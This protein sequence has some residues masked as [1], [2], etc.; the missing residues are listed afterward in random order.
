PSRFR[1]P[2]PLQAETEAI[3]EAARLLASAQ[4]PVIVADYVGRNHEA[5]SSLVELADLLSIPVVDLGARLNFPN[6]HALNLTGKNQD[7]IANADVF[8]GLDV[9]DLYGVLVK[10]DPE[11]HTVRP[12]TKAGCKVIHV[13]VADLAV[14]SLTSDF[15]ELAPV[16]LPITA[17]TRVFLPALV[18]EVRRDGKFSKS[19]VEERRKVLAAQHD[20]MHS[21]WENI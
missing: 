4:N 13:T 19:V 16:D 9:T 7:L 6:T 10:Q 1:P 5:V 2:A 21:H 8:M 20:E 15:Q 14:R 12:A 18:D 17:N 3:K 11:T